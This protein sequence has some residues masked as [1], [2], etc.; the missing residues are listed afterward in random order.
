[1][2]NLIPEVI[3]DI[4]LEAI[5][6]IPIL[7]V[8]WGIGYSVYFIVFKARTAAQNTYRGRADYT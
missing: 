3:V 1:M 4:A 6:C 2:Y 7:L 8:L 5:S